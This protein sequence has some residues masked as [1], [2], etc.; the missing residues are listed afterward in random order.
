MKRD[1][2]VKDSGEARPRPPPPCRSP[3]APGSLFLA[4]KSAHLV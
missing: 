4:P 2:G 3:G 1:A